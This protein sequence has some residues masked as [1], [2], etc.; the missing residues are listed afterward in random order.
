MRIKSQ[1]IPPE[2][3]LR[4]RP[5]DRQQIGVRTPEEAAGRVVAKLEK[6]LQGQCE[7]LLRRLGI[8]YLHLSIRAREKAGLPDLLFACNGI[9]MAVELKAR[10][11]KPEPH[12]IEMMRRM[13]KNGW[14]TFVVRAYEDFRLIVLQAMLDGEKRSA[15]MAV[16]EIDEVL[17]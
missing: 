10:D 17:Q 15:T 13:A 16:N 7:S 11:E 8:E 9:P 3:L 1:F 2:I 6:T 12:Q 5:A 14:Q 4:M